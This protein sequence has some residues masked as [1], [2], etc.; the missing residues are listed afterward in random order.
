MTTETG[1]ASPKKEISRDTV[2]GFGVGTVLVGGLVGLGI[3]TVDDYF[4]RQYSEIIHENGDIPL[5][6]SDPIIIT[7]HSGQG[8]ISVEITDPGIYISTIQAVCDDL[9]SDDLTGNTEE[10]CNSSLGHLGTEDAWGP[11]NLRASMPI[12]GDQ[13]VLGGRFGGSRTTKDELVTSITQNATIGDRHTMNELAN[14]ITFW[15]AIAG[16]IMVSTLILTKGVKMY[17]AH[18][19]KRQIA[20]N[21]KKESRRKRKLASVEDS[22]ANDT[23]EPGSAGESNDGP[24]YLY[25]LTE[26]SKPLAG[27]SLPPGFDPADLKPKPEKPEK[28]YSPWNG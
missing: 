9:G 14:D 11:V 3:I 18:L 23:I 1:V 5:L 25:A 27:I 17:D 7:D 4:N 22:D 10:D 8:T 13:V 19:K 24:D 20:A 12:E 6:A 28:P 26:T 2:I 21:D 16:A 15:S